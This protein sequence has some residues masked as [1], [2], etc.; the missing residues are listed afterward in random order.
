MLPA[1][2]VVSS[3]YLRLLTFLLEILIQACNSSSLAF[4]MMTSIYKLNKQD[5][6][7]QSCHTPFSTLNDSIVPYKVLTVA[8]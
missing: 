8:S 4:L 5:D 7:K 1:I 6:N 3:A 2:R